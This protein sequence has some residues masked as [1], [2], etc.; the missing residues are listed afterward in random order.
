LLQVS[1]AARYL[2]REEFGLMALVLVVIGFAERVADGGLNDAMLRFRVP[3]HSQLCAL[4]WVSIGLGFLLSASVA[5]VA[6]AAELVWGDSRLPALL[7]AAGCVFVLTGAGQVSAALLRRELR[8]GSFAALDLVRAAASLVAVVVLAP[9]GFGVWALV[10]GLLLGQTMRTLLALVLASRLFLPSAGGDFS[11]TRSMLSFGGYQL[12]ERMVRFAAWNVDKVLIGTVLGTEALGVYSLAYQLVSRPFQLLSIVGSRVL[13]PLLASLQ[14]DR[15]R[16][17]RAFMVALRSAALVAAPLFLGAFL[18]AEPLVELVY[19]EGW[20]RVASV[21]R[22]LC[23]LGMLYTVGNLDGALVV[24]TGKARVSFVWNCLSAAVHAAAV[25][26]ALRWGLEGVAAA[27]LVATLFRLLPGAC[28][29]RWL[30]I[31][32]PVLEYLHCLA[33]PAAYAFVMGVAVAGLGACVG[34]L[35]APF[36]I[37]LLVTTGAVVYGALLLAWERPFLLALR[38]S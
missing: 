3:S 34:D 7:G 10:A 22:I 35:A 9:A 11:G 17:L 30:L 2:E 27:I 6:W 4:F 21:F 24:A 5:I 31:R 18:L 32:M 15:D 1:I 8:F 25:G 13:R 36:A 26:I 14:T 29:L 33:R 16:V 20:G 38:G 23:P 12:G 28:Y 19:G 37:A